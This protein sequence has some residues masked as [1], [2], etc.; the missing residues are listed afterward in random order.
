MPDKLKRRQLIG[1]VS[2]PQ[3]QIGREAPA[4]LCCHWRSDTEIDSAYD[5]LQ[6]A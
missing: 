3:S 6:L 4:D 5:S 1:V 2:V